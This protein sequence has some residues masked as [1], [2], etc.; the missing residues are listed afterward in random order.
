MCYLIPISACLFQRTEKR[1]YSFHGFFIYGSSRFVNHDSNKRDETKSTKSN[2]LDPI[3]SHSKIYV[4]TNR[5][6]KF[7][8]SKIYFQRGRA[9]T[10]KGRLFLASPRIGSG[11]ST[12]EQHKLVGLKGEKKKEKK[13]YILLPIHRLPFPPLF[14]VQGAFWSSQKSSSV[15][16]LLPAAVIYILVPPSASTQCPLKLNSRPK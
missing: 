5:K 12:A 10:S 14:A 3:Q 13:N 15:V 8:K 11:E 2:L 4:G 6:K 9:F 16:L 1:G 7:Q